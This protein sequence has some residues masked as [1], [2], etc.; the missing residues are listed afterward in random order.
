MHGQP[1][2]K[3]MK[4]EFIQLQNRRTVSDSCTLVYSV[5]LLHTLQPN[6]C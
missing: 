6:D 4:G 2:I 3:I 5:I 1:Y